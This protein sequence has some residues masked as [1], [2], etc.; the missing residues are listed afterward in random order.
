MVETPINV[1]IDGNEYAINL[2]WIEVKKTDN[3]SNIKKRESKLRG[4][5]TVS[6]D[7]NNNTFIGF[8]E[9]NQIEK[10]SL[11][12]A[13]ALYEKDAI[14]I[15]RLDSIDK[16]W[17]N[18]VTADGRLGA[19]MSDVIVDAE[20]VV[21]IISELL[22][23]FS[24]DSANKLKI[25][26]TNETIEELQGS[27]DEAERYRIFGDNRVLIQTFDI[28]SIVSG[29]GSLLSR[30]ETTKG[31]GSTSAVK[32]ISYVAGLL[33][34]GAGSYLFI[35]E[36][37]EEYESLVNGEYSS[38]V[39]TQESNLEKSIKSKTSLFVE[40]KITS[41]IKRNFID[42][43]DSNIY[44]LPEII[45]YIEMLSVTFPTYL[46]EWEVKDIS[47]VKNEDL[48][49]DYKI[50]YSRIKDSFG[51]YN[52][53]ESSVKTIIDSID[54]FSYKIEPT[55]IGRNS[56]LLSIKFKEDYKEKEKDSIDEVM[57]NIKKSTSKIDAKL[58][59]TK[60]KVKTIEN[61]AMD[62]SFLDKRFGSSLNEAIN[63][64]EDLSMELKSNIKDK[65]TIYNKLFQT[66]DVVIPD[67]YYNLTRERFL[68]TIQENNHYNWDIDSRSVGIPDNAKDIKKQKDILIKKSKKSK[69]DDVDMNEDDW[70]IGY[71]W[72]F[73][74][75]STGD[76]TQGIEGLR[77]LME[78]IN[79]KSITI[80]EVNYNFNSENW[81]LSGEFY[82]KK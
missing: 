45:D 57:E 11:A 75:S 81:S 27:L 79:N 2:D 17:L 68:N 56:L 58:S 16:F 70:V 60:N 64:V 1:K 54:N 43:V 41:D 33:V 59:S 15:Y 61:D 7:S 44:D 13:T 78:L 49:I 12:T 9:K 18:Y 29:K 28:N 8:A 24:G 38:D 74:V 31:G 6:F 67:D 51:I 5:N 32:I 14:Y 80:K 52:E 82:E 25:Y 53:A 36:P 21:D 3:L 69:K 48:S 26:S 35:S 55:D 46:V 20:K 50:P 4:N 71:S 22:I 63:E 47:F 37:P 42:A 30:I 34:V 76:G 77:K 40:S 72:G 23:I 65:E 73:R 39:A 19:S 66:V 62:F 10:I